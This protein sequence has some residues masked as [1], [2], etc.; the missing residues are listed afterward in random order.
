MAIYKN[1]NG[2][3]SVTTPPRSEEDSDLSGQDRFLTVT[4]D[5]HFRI[6]QFICI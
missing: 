2:R 5:K 4:S 3:N 1:D 6:D